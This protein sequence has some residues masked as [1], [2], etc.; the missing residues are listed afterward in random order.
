[1]VPS[2][3]QSL[4]F[5]VSFAALAQGCACRPSV[6]YQQRRGSRFLRALGAAFDEPSVANHRRSQQPFASTPRHAARAPRRRIYARSW[7]AALGVSTGRVP[8]ARTSPTRNPLKETDNAVVAIRS[9]PIEADRRLESLNRRR[10]RCCASKSHR[11]PGETA[12]NVQSPTTYVTRAYLHISSP[13]FT[14]HAVPKIELLAN[15]SNIPATTISARAFISIEPP[16]EIS[17]S[18]KAAMRSSTCA[19]LSRSW[20]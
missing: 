12:I 4:L 8:P 5:K 6:G 1:M 15:S 18:A 11:K 13:Q 2:G 17:P 14:F 9:R 10:R 3:S 19:V 16:A 7:L 20:A